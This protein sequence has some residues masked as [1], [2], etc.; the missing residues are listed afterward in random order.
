MQ[1]AKKA[2]IAASKTP[3]NDASDGLLFCVKRENTSLF[4]ITAMTEKR[5]KFQLYIIICMP[6]S[7]KKAHH[8]SFFMFEHGLTECVAAHR[9]WAFN[10]DEA[11]KRAPFVKNGARCV[12]CCRHH[13]G[14][15]AAVSV[16]PV[17]VVKIRVEPF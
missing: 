9:P 12:S 11:K 1:R 13:P 3:R 16:G 5:D 7:M 14:H 4:R 15:H 6:K 10:P 17:P 8:R 2:W